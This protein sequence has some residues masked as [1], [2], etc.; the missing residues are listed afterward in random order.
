MNGVR[1]EFEAALKQTAKGVWYCDGVRTGAQTIPELGSK[2][3]LLMVEIEQVLLK[4]NMH[5][6]AEDQGVN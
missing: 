6:D 4:H 1:V 5:A 2:C 3:D